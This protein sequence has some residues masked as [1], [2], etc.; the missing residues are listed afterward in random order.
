MEGLGGN[1][2][3]VIKTLYSTDLLVGDALRGETKAG[4]VIPSAHMAEYYVSLQNFLDS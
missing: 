4:G 3:H 1:M 2:Y